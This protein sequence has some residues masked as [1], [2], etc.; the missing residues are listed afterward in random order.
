MKINE[1]ELTV[2]KLANYHGR[3]NQ[4]EHFISNV[5]K[6]EVNTGTGLVLI[7]NG[8]SM[9]VIWNKAHFF[10]FDSHSRDSKVLPCENGT[11]VLLKFHSLLAIEK[12]L[13]EVYVKNGDTVLFDLQY[14]KIL[15]HN[16]IEF[17]RNDSVERVKA[18]KRK[19]MA[20]NCN[21][22]KSSE[23][24]A[25]KLEQNK[26]YKSKNYKTILVKNNQY[27]A[28]NYQNVL[29]NNM[30]YKKH[31]FESILEKNRHYKED[32]Y[33]NILEKN[34]QYM[35]ENYEIILEKNR[36]YKVKRYLLKN[37]GE[38][39]KSEVR[40][41][42]YYICVICNRS[43][44]KRSVKIFHS[45]KYNMPSI[46]YFYVAHIVSFNDKVYICLTCDKKLIK[47]EVPCQ[48]VCNKLEIFDF[49]PYL[50]KL[51]HLEKVIYF[52]FFFCYL[53]TVAI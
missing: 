39:F 49:P 36:Q 29:K 43:L 12:Y 33:Q 24:Y 32:N 42:P 7:F 11:A 17:Q 8:F 18:C 20:T 45:Q 38:R 35:E 6:S 22:F 34:R 52:F 2:V 25:T 3:L 21:A 53:I 28:E 5:H 40:D 16:E 44:C 47:S 46:S 41:G 4:V 23:K 48:A 10:L 13:L 1:T 9:S 15:S 14:I 19:Y 27:I 50:I 26:R 37:A 31:N 30:Q 51:R